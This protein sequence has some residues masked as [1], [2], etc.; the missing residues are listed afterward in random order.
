MFCYTHSRVGAVA[1]L[2]LYREDHPRRKVSLSQ[3]PEK[4]K[5]VVDVL[6]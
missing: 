5:M 6:G 1:D 2:G 3:I 4:G